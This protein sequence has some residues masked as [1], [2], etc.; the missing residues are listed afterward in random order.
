MNWCFAKYYTREATHQRPT[1]KQTLGC[2]RFTGD[3]ESVMSMLL[4]DGLI[5]DSTIRV[6]YCT[7]LAVVSSEMMVV[8]TKLTDN[9]P[10]QEQLT[11]ISNYVR[12]QILDCG[13]IEFLILPLFF[14]DQKFWTDRDW[15]L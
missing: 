12:L 1:V 15:V 14:H 4:L 8:T 7:V 2:S 13:G 11:D 10:G 5:V 9:D 6:L 3:D